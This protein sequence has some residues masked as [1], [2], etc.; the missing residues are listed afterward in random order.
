[1]TL[2]EVAK[3]WIESSPLPSTNHSLGGEPG[4]E[5]SQATLLTTGGVQTAACDVAG[6]IAKSAVRATSARHPSAGLWN[7]EYDPVLGID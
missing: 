5:F 6:A 3:P 7:E 4:W 1:V 2:I